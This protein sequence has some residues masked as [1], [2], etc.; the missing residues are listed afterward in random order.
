MAVWDKNRLWGLL[1]LLAGAV[2]QTVIYPFW[3]TCAVRGSTVT[4][5]C[6]FTPPFNESEVSRET[7]R[8]R[9]YQSRWYQL[10]QLTKP[11][12]YDSDSKNNTQRFEYLGD[13]KTNCTLQIRDVQEKVC[14]FHQLEVT[15][16]KDGHAL[17][18]TG[19]SLQL[20]HLTAEDSGNYTCALKINLT[21][22]SEPYSLQVTGEAGVKLG[23]LTVVRLVLF[24]AHTVLIIIMASIIIKRKYCLQVSSRELKM[25]GS[26]ASRRH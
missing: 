2:G 12:V 14:T 7:I 26:S 23:K 25:F 21:T 8:V 17:S 16:F 18:E 4:L 13:K 20:G 24:S 9:W 11:F 19:P 6:T 22:L 3:S 10:C 15:W 5:P 1:F